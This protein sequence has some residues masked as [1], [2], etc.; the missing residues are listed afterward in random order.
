MGR[1]LADGVPPHLLAEIDLAFARAGELA[2]RNRE[3]HFAQCDPDAPIVVEV[4]DLDG[5][6]I[7]TIAGAEA[8]DV[9]SGAELR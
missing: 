9:L 8:L 1:F 7:R 2:A 4:R 6:L 3:L 5:A